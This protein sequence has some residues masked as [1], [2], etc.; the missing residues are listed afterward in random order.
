LA[1]KAAKLTDPKFAGD[2]IEW[3]RQQPGLS[4]SYSVLLEAL[5]PQPADRS[6]ILRAYFE[7]SDAEAEQ[8]LKSP[9]ELHR[10]L[11]KLVKAGFI[12]VILTTNFDRLVE[13]ALASE[14]ISPVVVTS[15]VAAE[16]MPPLQHSSCTIVK[17]NGDYQ[18]LATRNT[19]ME[20]KSYPP[21]LNELLARI[22]TEYGIIICGW[23]GE[24][25]HALR[26]ALIKNARCPFSTF[27]MKHG[28]LSERAA[29]VVSIRQAIVFEVESGDVAF[30][31]LAR[32][33]EALDSKSLADP[34][35][36]RAVLSVAKR[37]IVRAEDRVRLH[38]LV[39]ETCTDAQTEARRIKQECA[40]RPLEA[41][42]IK[43]ALQSVKATTQ[44]SACAFF[45]CGRWGGA[46]HEM[47]WR[48]ELRRLSIVSH[49][50]G[51]INSFT[52]GLQHLPAS[53]AFYAA[54]IGLMSSEKWHEL[55]TLFETTIVD[56]P[57]GGR[58]SFAE[59][60]AAL[61]VLSHDALNAVNKLDGISTRK[62]PASDWMAETIGDLLASEFGDRAT[63]ESAFDR[64][65]VL[66]AL[67]CV[68]ITRSATTS[69]AGGAPWFPPG[70]FA[71]KLEAADS[72]FLRIRDEVES[73]GAAWSPLAAVTA[74]MRVEDARSAIRHI[75]DVLPRY[76]LL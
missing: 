28:A 25:D 29:E 71:W 55:R 30:G 23:S 33:V 51:P 27:W 70:R 59:R 53:I 63:F 18:D 48:P 34:R 68:D 1:G 38:D 46:D 60:L 39:R 36:F 76:G 20:L 75:C 13:T 6:G 4:E 57:G 7:P 11:A 5:A 3:I 21:A 64:F 16:G 14:G 26:E 47:C 9:T 15:A 37:F 52:Q 32:Q 19:E 44:T 49:E 50:S 65:E 17:L 41:A 40:A 8:G 12:R 31:N 35:S 54:G 67:A 74:S 42:T 22:F 2:P 72:P 66:L 45:V 43:S 58:T 69:A 73:D 62:L 61:R 56:V 24:W 10:S